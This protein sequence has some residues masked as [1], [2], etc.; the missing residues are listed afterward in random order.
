MLLMICQGEVGIVR[1]KSLLTTAPILL[2][3]SLRVLVACTAVVQA[4]RFCFLVIGEVH[5]SVV[6]V[7][8]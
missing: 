6:G 2:P 8:F 1:L 7:A 3:V 4:R 5:R